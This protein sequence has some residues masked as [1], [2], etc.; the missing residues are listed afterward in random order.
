MLSK[1]QL[2]T[3]ALVCRRFSQLAE[4]ESL[5]T[6]MDISNRTLEKGSNW[7]NNESSSD[8]FKTVKI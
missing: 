6:R 7:D 3:V 4:D 1:A 2:G 5:W 8:Y